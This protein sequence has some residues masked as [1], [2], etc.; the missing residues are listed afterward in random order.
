MNPK[1]VRIK[2]NSSK[3]VVE[4]EQKFVAEIYITK[5]KLRLLAEKHK[6]LEVEA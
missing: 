4:T 2:S 3:R 5:Q 1:R 6:A